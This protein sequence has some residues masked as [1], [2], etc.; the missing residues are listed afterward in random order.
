MIDKHLTSLLGSLMLIATIT[1]MGFVTEAGQSK[2][3]AL[4]P[5]LA[6]SHT[7][8]QKKVYP[9]IKLP[10]HT[11]KA[12]LQ[13]KAW[14]WLKNRGVPKKQWVCLKK[15]IH[16]ES[17]WIPNLWNSQGSDAYGLGQV[18]G[19]YHYTKNKPMKQFKVA[20]RYALHKYEQ[21]FCKALQHHYAHGWY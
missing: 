9:P 4:H 14:L 6:S 17:R 15:V 10:P 2:S 12:V 8:A 7:Y 18:K 21:S 20:V 13:Q 19:S 16:L 5:S 3:P 11:K 1:L